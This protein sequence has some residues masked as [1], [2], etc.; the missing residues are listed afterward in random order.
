M[1]VHCRLTLRIEILS[2]AEDFCVFLGGERNCMNTIILSKEALFITLSR[3]FYL[4]KRLQFDS[5]ALSC[6]NAKTWP[7]GWLFI[8]RK[9][10][11][12]N[13]YVHVTSTLPTSMRHV[14]RQWSW[15][16]HFYLGLRQSSRC[17][18][19]KTVRR[20]VD[21][22]TLMFL[23]SFIFGHTSVENVSLSAR[24]N[25]VSPPFS[26]SFRY[27]K[28]VASLQ[29]SNNKVINMFDFFGHSVFFSRN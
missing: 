23:Q 12:N 5:S 6:Q 10:T 7:Y 17:H 21:W 20:S 1:L 8:R 9:W 3:L 27:S 2:A 18:A 28:T 4:A 14:A 11:T 29:Y 22:V 13:C 24:G 15:P 26:G 19:W 16:R 25:A